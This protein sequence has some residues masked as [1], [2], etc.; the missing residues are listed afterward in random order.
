MF[1][2]TMIA[3]F[4]TLVLAMSFSGANARGCV[5]GEESTISAYPAYA[6]CR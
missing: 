4:A 5:S 1:R 6:V 2:N 3:L